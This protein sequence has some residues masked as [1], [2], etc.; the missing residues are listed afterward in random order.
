[1][2]RLLRRLAPRQRAMVYLTVVEGCTAREAAS[3][4]GIL[5]A[6]ARVHRHRALARLR[7]ALEEHR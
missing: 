6:T 1:M 5:P 3:V 7:R 4:L 2:A